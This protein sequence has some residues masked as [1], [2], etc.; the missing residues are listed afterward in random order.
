LAI[1]LL[2]K[3]FVL[4]YQPDFRALAIEFTYCDSSIEPQLGEESLEGGDF[5]QSRQ[6]NEQPANSSLQNS[7]KKF[8]VET[9]DFIGPTRRLPL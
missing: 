3:L 5:S 6:L 2:F 7:F 4:I 9:S 1:K 8:S